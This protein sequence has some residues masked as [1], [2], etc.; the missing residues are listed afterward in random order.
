MSIHNKITDNLVN[1]SQEEIEENNDAEPEDLVGHNQ[2]ILNNTL[3]D[4][5]TI[6]IYG[7]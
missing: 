1:D 7:R 6:H 5:W 3:D 2:D 4:I